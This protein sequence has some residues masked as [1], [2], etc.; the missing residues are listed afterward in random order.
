MAKSVVRGLL[1]AAALVACS[2]AGTS[3]PSSTSSAEGPA[4]GAPGS[5]SSSSSSSSEQAGGASATAPGGSRVARV[6]FRLVDAPTED[7]SAIF[8]TVS[9]IDASIGGA[10]K[11]LVEGSS[12]V[13]LLTLQ[14]GKFLDLGTAALPP[15]R[16]DQL[17]LHLAPG[18]DHHVQTPDGVDHPLTIPSGEQS[19]IKLVGGFDVPECASGAVTL[20]FDGKKS[21][22]VHPSG[23]DGT[24]YSLR[25]VVRIK[26]IALAGSCEDAADAGAEGGAGDDAAA[27]PPPDPCAAI[28]CS[29]TEIC[30]NGAC[31]P[32]AAP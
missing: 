6:A 13:D 31:R 14:G 15:G 4:A 18:G 30:E 2:S 29:D 9:R 16:V 20:D 23:Q 25:P 3:D 8:V 10:W 28:T 5:S 17:R 22:M 12:T 7:V 21:L 26:A 1:I 19:G 32:A 11:T 24:T 27:E